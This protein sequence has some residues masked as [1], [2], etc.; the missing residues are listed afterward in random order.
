MRNSCIIDP[1]L[2]FPLTSPSPPSLISGGFSHYGNHDDISNMPV[3]R[4]CPWEGVNE[5]RK[6]RIKREAV[7]EGWEEMREGVEGKRVRLPLLHCCMLP[8]QL[9]HVGRLS[10]VFPRRK[11]HRW[12]QG[13]KTAWT[14]LHL[15]RQCH[16]PISSLATLTLL[17]TWLSQYDVPIRYFRHWM[18]DS[19]CVRFIH[20]AYH[21]LSNLLYL[22]S[23]V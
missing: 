19:H 3:V 23:K 14:Y 10:A 4:F 17:L 13:L 5:T 12:G 11:L 22:C 15:N 20:W 9:Q 6:W 7:K 2:P 21:I 8:G 1:S 16:T 18:R